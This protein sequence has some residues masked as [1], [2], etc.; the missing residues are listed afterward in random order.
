MAASAAHGV[1]IRRP[2]A[3]DLGKAP[4]RRI[5]TAKCAPPA[6]STNRHR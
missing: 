1:D 5:D 4:R 3:G 6:G 2:A